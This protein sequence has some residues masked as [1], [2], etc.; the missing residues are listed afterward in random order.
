MLRGELGL[1]QRCLNR[2]TGRPNALGEERRRNVGA[3][4]RAF[5]PVQARN[6]RG[7]QPDGR[8]AVSSAR[9]RQCG[10]STGIARQRQ[11]TSSRPVGRDVESR[12]IRVRALFAVAG[13]V[14]VNQT[15]IPLRNIL[16]LQL[17]FLARPMRSVDDEHVGPFDQ[18][19]QNLPR[20][21][22]FQVQSQSTL[23]TVVQMP[24]ISVFGERLRGEPVRHPPQ[25]AHGWFDFDDIGAEVRQNHGCARTG[26]E[27]RKIDNLHSR[28]DVV[29]CRCV[30][31]WH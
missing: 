14:S 1:A 10:G 30:F 31:S 27:A 16:I 28:E 3:F 17:E 26:D 7:K 8:W 6:D 20:V 12:K 2:D 18:A 15:W 11:Q 5:A 23:V 9:E 19:L 4:A 29:A 13:Q 22:R 24:L 25:L 21:G